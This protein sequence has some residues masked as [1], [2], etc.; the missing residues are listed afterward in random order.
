[1]S[2]F[3]KR[4]VLGFLI[5]IVAILGVALGAWVFAPRVPSTLE[6]QETAMVS[7]VTRQEV[8]DS[9]T[10]ELNFTFESSDSLYSASAGLVTGIN[11]PDDNVLVS[12]RNAFSVGGENVVALNTEIPLWR[13]LEKGD[14][15]KDV[16]A[17]QEAL[18]SLG[19]SLS[20]DGEVGAYTLNA[21]ADLF[22]LSN[23]QKREF[24]TIDPASFLW[25]P[26]GS[27][28][29]DKILFGV[30][31]TIDANTE[32]FSVADTLTTANIVEVPK[33]LLPGERV[34]VLGETKVPVDSEG[35]VSS[36]DG[37]AALMQSREY[38]SWAK[39]S[40]SN[41]A[42]T[43]KYVL[44]EPSSV[45]A[46]AP[47]SVYGLDGSLGC[48]TNGEETFPISILSSELGK[49]LVY[50]D[51]P[52]QTVPQQVLISPSEAPACR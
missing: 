21:V 32:L 14:K 26:Y 41:T 51:D 1:M 52:E 9:R 16:A 23:T 37:L 10:V 46:V 42:L 28:V 38:L 25:I 5:F 7:T 47:A 19:Y 4:L 39:N 34:L 44:E 2:I 11:V 48:L 15:G 27:V 33:N 35:N 3:S 40:E 29:V 22:G 30:G 43:A 50:F 31:E 12:G 45:Y 20:A 17:L 36:N 18:S 49:T 13:T 8:D 6:G 24:T